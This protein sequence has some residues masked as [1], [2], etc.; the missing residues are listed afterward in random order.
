MARAHYWQYLLN[1]EG[2]PVPYAQINVYDTGSLT[3]ATIYETDVSISP[4]P[5]GMMYTEITGF[6]NFWAD[7]NDYPTGMYFDITW[8]KAG[9]ITAGGVDNVYLPMAYSQVDEGDTDTTKDKLVSNNQAR[10]WNAKPNIYTT[11][12]VS[13]SGF[14]VVSAGQPATGYDYYYHAVHGF[15]QSYPLVTVHISGGLQINSISEY[16]TDSTLRIWLKTEDVSAADRAFNF[17][18]VG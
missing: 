11:T 5:S 18:L 10:L 17:T 3:P 2:Q 8:S 7:P 15:D 4:I 1:E 16:Y 6:F 14:A 9:S 13:I 12:G